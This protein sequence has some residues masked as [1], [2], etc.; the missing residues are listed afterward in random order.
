MN[1]ELEVLKE[2]NKQNLSV[3]N[4]PYQP[5]VYALLEEQ[6]DTMLRLQ[7]D[8]V[9]FQP[10]MWEKI[11]TLASR[12][13]MQKYQ[14]QLMNTEE[15]YMNQTVEYIKKQLLKTQ[16]EVNNLMTTMQSQL[17]QAGKENENFCFNMRRELNSSLFQFQ[18]MTS[19]LFRRLLIAMGT[20]VILSAALSA[21]LMIFLKQ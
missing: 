12:E 2:R 15:R 16:S 1:S 20:S 5:I 6:W 11:S 3:M 7:T 10:K 4:K 19:K 13:E 21:L 8:T 9:S 14:S 17:K 18:Q